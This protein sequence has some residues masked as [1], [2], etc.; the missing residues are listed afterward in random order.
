MAVE[1]RGLE[2]EEGGREERGGGGVVMMKM[3]IGGCYR[4]SPRTR[5]RTHTCAFIYNWQSPAAK[6]SPDLLGEES[7]PGGGPSSS[8]AK[9]KIATLG[10]TPRWGI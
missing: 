6:R 10:D 3:S 7:R 1:V 4:S 5:F 2:K 8:P 9:T